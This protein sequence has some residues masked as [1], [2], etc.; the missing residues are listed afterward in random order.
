MLHKEA[1]KWNWDTLSELIEGPLLNQ[2]RFEEAMKV[3][4]VGR[5]V[6]SFFHPNS[7]AFS[8]IKNTKVRVLSHATRCPL[9]DIFRD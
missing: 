1:I 8:E 6:M 5:K 4:R 2:K 7:K 9:L 3:S